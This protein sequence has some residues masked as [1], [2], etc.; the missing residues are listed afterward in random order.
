MFVTQA[1]LFLFQ[2]KRKLKPGLALKIQRAAVWGKDMPL[3]SI[4]IPCYNHGQFVDEAVQSILEQTWQ[5]LEI[6]IVNDGSDDRNTIEVLQNFSRPKTRVLHLPQNMKPS[7]ARN[8][9]INE[10]KGKYI[11]CL[12]ADDK[13]HPTYIEKAITIMEANAGI[14]FIWTWVQVFGNE[15]RV[16]YTEQFHA[17]NMLFWSYLTVPSVFRKSTWETC[18]GFREEMREGCEDWEFWIRLVGNGF[19]GFRIS[20]KLILVRKICPSFGQ[21]ALTMR[22]I[23]FERIKEYNPGIY[24]DPKAVI[25]KAERNYCDIYNPSPFANLSGGGHLQMESAPQM[26]I[27]DLDSEATI[28][29]LKNQKGESLLVWVAGQ[30]VSEEA[31]DL[32]FKATPYVYVLPNFL[33]SYA[34]FEFTQNLKKAWKIKSVKKLNRNSA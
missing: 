14:S 24:T 30:P 33:P 17:Y 6:I 32:L 19:R 25:E 34:R 11:C 20:E 13:L 23:L 4:V 22:D 9:G 8:A 29:Y 15:D 27:S 5:N 7:A 3:V 31:Q 10:A 26:V 18:G 2:L 21:R 16:W 1:L 28:S 12:D